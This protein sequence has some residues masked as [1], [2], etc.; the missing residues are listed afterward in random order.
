M[1]RVL[2]LCY[3]A[4]CYCVFFATFLY[5]IGFV[6]NLVVPKSVDSGVGG[7]IGSALLINA[8]LL[9]LF[10]VQHSG[11]ARQSFKAWWTRLV[12]G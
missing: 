4:V 9:S 5:A 8:A 2:A 7:P 6:E 1:R 12:P 10:A 3:G 11:M